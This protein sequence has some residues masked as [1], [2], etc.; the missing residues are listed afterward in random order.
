MLF[1]VIIGK[2]VDLDG[3]VYKKDEVIKS[4]FALDERFR[5]KFKRVLSREDFVK[6]TATKKKAKAK[7]KLSKKKKWT[8]GLGT[9]VTG[10]FS[11]ASENDLFVFKKGAYFHVYE[12]GDKTPANSKGLKKTKVKSFINGWLEE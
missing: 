6:P 5:G 4:D 9:N 7:V 10:E 8:E 1:Q 12:D 11:V 2:H 3:T